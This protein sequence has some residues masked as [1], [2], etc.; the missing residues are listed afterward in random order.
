MAE[1]RG[2]YIA[3]TG[4]YLPEK[5]LTN[6][7]LEKMVD[8]TDEWIRKM[9]GMK[10]RHVAGEDQATSD[11]CVEAAKNALDMAGMGPED[12]DLILVGTITPDMM[13]PATAPLVQDKLGCK[14]IPAFDFSIACSGFVYGLQMAQQFV[15]TG[16]YNN[17]LL[18]S[19]DILT[20]ITDYTDRDTCVLF[21]DAAAAAIISPSDENKMKG[22]D[23]GSDGSEIEILY[24][25][26]GGSKMPATVESVENRM[27]YLKM[28]GPSVFKLAV[29]KMIAGLKNACKQ[30]GCKPTDLDWIIPHQANIRIMETVTKFAKLNPEQL[31]NTIEIHANTSASTVGCALDISIRDGKIKRGDLIGLTAF[32]AGLSWA[33]AVFEF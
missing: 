1:L 11:L 20:R 14:N 19:A 18:I 27:H 15:S 12:I 10:I 7:D 21:G 6:A 31:I 30:A 2:T 25:P 8:T 22:F 17:V 32:G 26:A 23:L 5:I 28:T 16:A 4:H 9:T 24:Q 29:S 13:F 3:G 33:G